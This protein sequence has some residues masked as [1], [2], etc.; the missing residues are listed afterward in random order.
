MN[1]GSILLAFPTDYA[2][3]LVADL[4][5]LVRVNTKDV[6]PIFEPLKLKLAKLRTKDPVAFLG[7]RLKDALKFPSSEPSYKTKLY[8]DRNVY[9]MDSYS[10]P[11]HDFY[12]QLGQEEMAFFRET[13][14]LR[15]F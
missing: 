12:A 6:V 8:K 5:W 7:K 14:R 3:N 11:V 13:W 9:H 15:I 4:L 2:T 1:E 10:C